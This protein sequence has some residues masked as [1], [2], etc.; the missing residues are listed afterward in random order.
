MILGFEYQDKRLYF[1]SITLDLGIGVST[2]PGGPP[3]RAYFSELETVMHTPE[4]LADELRKL[5]G[6]GADPSRLALKPV[7]R[8]LAG[9][10]P[11]LPRITAGSI[12]RRY[13]EGALSSLEGVYEFLGTKHDA[14]KMNRAYRLL[15]GFEGRSLTAEARRYRVMEMLG[16]DYSYDAWRKSWH[17]ERGLLL[18]L[19]ETMCA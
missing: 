19:A 13:L 1:E 5:V 6:W 8:Q 16:V 11:S 12:V 4:I 3:A 17:L 9:V 2:P 15:L 18:L 14:H 7:L 10:E